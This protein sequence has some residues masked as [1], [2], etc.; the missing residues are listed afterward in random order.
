MAMKPLKIWKP[1]E[2]K[3]PE[4]PQRYLMLVEWGDEVAVAVVDRNGAPLPMGNLLLINPSTGRTKRALAI[5]RD[6]GLDL[7]GSGSVK[8]ATHE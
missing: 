4:E 6:I 8:I 1:K 5:N 7:D 3:P 2:E